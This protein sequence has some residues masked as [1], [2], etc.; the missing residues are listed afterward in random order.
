MA[1][2]LEGN[3]L[4]AAIL[5]AGIIASGAGVFSR[6]VYSPHHLP[7]S[8]YPIEVAEVVDE[9]EPVE[10]APIEMRLAAADADAG[11]GAFRQCAACH[12]VE[13]GAPHRVGPALWDVVGRDIAAIDGF[14]FSS[15]LQGIDGDW[16]YEKLDGF[17]AD[18]RGWAPGTSMSFAGV[19]NPDQRADL[20][21]YLRSLSSDPMPLPDEG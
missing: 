20:I 15:A 7:E 6:I 5:T 13:E 12:T 3:K 10:E 16:T 9:E 19:R 14:S 18:P 11:Q 2:S 21:A 1:S 17:L 8:I 4:L